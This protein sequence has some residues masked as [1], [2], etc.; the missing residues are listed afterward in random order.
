MHSG[1]LIDLISVIFQLTNNL[2]PRDSASV[3]KLLT[4]TTVS[5][6]DWL[7]FELALL[8]LLL[9]ISSLIVPNIVHHCSLGLDKKKTKHLGSQRVNN[10]W[11]Y[12]CAFAAVALKYTHWW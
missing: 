12:C 6:L 3:S 7:T 8:V 4:A 2:R 10:T 11:L 9:T 1:S 5:A